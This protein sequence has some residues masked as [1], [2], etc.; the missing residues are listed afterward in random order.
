MREKYIVCDKILLMLVF[1]DLAYNYELQC[2]AKANI[3]DE[4]FGTALLQ[5]CMCCMLF[6]DQIYH[7]VRYSLTR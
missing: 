4:C 7:F 3:W 2:W 6:M 5:D 1:F